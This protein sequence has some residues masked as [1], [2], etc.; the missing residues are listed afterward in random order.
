MEAF[1]L[2]SSSPPS[3]P[4]PFAHIAFSQGATRALVVKFADVKKTHT[5]KGWLVP[6]GRG[7][8]PIGFNGGLRQGG[9]PAANYWHATVPPG[10]GGGGGGARDVYPKGREVYPAPYPYQV[11]GLMCWS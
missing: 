3:L 6:D 7:A 4:P 8:S 5:A 11:R 2:Y 10:G 9:S 1:W